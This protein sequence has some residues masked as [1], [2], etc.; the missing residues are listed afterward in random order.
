MTTE[1]RDKLLIEM[2]VKM[3]AMSSKIED[4]HDM[5]HGDGNNSKGWNTRI[6]L[7]EDRQKGIFWGLGILFVTIATSIGRWVYEHIR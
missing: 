6:A 2:K 5:A 4:L 3:D 1:E 7:L